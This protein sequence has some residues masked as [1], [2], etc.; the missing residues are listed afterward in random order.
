MATLLR[1]GAL[2][3]VARC[4]SDSTSDSNHSNV[5]DY[6]STGSW[7]MVDATEILHDALRDGAD[8]GTIRR[9]LPGTNLLAIPQRPVGG[10]TCLN[11][12]LAPPNPFYGYIPFTET[13]DNA[14]RRS[15]VF[16]LLLNT[17]EHRGELRELFE[18]KSMINIFSR[19]SPTLNTHLED[20]LDAMDRVRLCVEASGCQAC[21]ALRGEVRHALP[22]HDVPNAITDTILTFLPAPAPKFGYPVCLLRD[23]V[24]NNKMPC[25]DHAFSFLDSYESCEIDDCVRCDGTGIRIGSVHVYVA[26][27]PLIEVAIAYNKLIANINLERGYKKLG[28]GYTAN[29]IKLDSEGAARL[30]TEVRLLV[31]AG[32][33]PD[34][35]VRLRCFEGLQMSAVEVARLG[36]SDSK[37]RKYLEGVSREREC[38]MREGVLCRHGW[39]T[40]NR[41]HDTY[42]WN[43]DTKVSQWELPTC[44]TRKHRVPLSSYQTCYRC[45]GG[46]AF[47]GVP[48]CEC[49]KVKRQRCETCTCRRCEGEGT[50]RVLLH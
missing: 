18:M 27:P 49:D 10:Y 22:K 15:G 43:Q 41:K 28:R 21:N 1:L 5:T 12:D 50:V 30:L 24:L 33:D 42:Y 40:V 19:I 39:T 14:H 2:F 38:T 29:G 8:A 4:S 36:P 48:G 31:N 26:P 13:A 6:D 11:L 45:N 20:F 9:L 34:R 44:V 46:G 3:A 25:T 37:L 35:R 23:R 7:V 32:A 47:Q 16:R 17:A